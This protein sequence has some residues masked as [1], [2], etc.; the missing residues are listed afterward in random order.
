MS[1]GNLVFM[2]LGNSAFV[3]VI[4]I[5]AYLLM[6]FLISAIVGSFMNVELEKYVFATMLFWPLVLVIGAIFQ[7]IRFVKNVFKGEY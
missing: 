6:G 7:L 2:S 3:V 1:L 4:I 5:G